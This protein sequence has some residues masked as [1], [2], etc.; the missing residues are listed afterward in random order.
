MVYMIPKTWISQKKDPKYDW[1]G[2]M[3]RITFFGLDPLYIYIYIFKNMYISFTEYRNSKNEQ[4]GTRECYDQKST[5]TAQEVAASPQTTLYNS[6]PPEKSHP[7]T[8][9]YISQPKKQNSKFMYTSK[10]SMSNIWK[11]SEDKINVC[12]WL[13]FE[14]LI[15]LKGWRVVT[16]VIF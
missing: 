3:L 1:T 13:A 7:I 12:L 5:L 15:E 10:N 11:D 2:S 9:A 4:W 6:Q 8:Q 14:V 16:V